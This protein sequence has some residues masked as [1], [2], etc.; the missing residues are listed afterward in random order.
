MTWIVGRRTA[1]EVPAERVPVEAPSSWA[2]IET[3]RAGLP[4]D[5]VVLFVMQDP[6]GVG[7]A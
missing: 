6:G 4:E 3:I 5:G 7:A 2:A 1:P